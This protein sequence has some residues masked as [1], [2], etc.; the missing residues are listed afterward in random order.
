MFLPTA[1]GI[2]PSFPPPHG[3]LGDTSALTSGSSENIPL[4]RALRDDGRGLHGGRPVKGQCPGGCD[5]SRGSH[6]D[7]KH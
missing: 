1:V 7:W 3:C 2:Q 6:G 4:C 5:L